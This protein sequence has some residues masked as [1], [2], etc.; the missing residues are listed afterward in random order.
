MATLNI[1]TMDN[2]WTPITTA[3]NNPEAIFKCHKCKR[4]VVMHPNF[5][6][7]GISGCVGSGGCYNTET[8]IKKMLNLRGYKFV[9]LERNGTNSAITIDFL[10]NNV[11]PH[12]SQLTYTCLRKGGS[13]KMCRNLSR[14]KD[15][16]NTSVVKNKCD[17]KTKVCKHY[18]HLLYYPESSLEWDYESNNGVKPEDIAPKS[19]KKKFWWKCSNVWCKMK[20]EQRAAAR[21]G[22]NGY[23]C[24]FCSGQKVC[25]WNC[26]A[27]THPGLTEELD[28]DN[29]IKPTQIT[30]GS[31]E[32]MSWICNKHSPPHKWV[33]SVKKRVA[34]GGC[35]KCNFDGYEQLV[36]GKEHFVSEANKT[37]KNKY[38]YPGEYIDN[39]T[40]INIYCPV[41]NKKSNLPHGNF[42]QNPKD[43]KRGS[44]CIKCT[45]ESISS[46]AL[47][48][49]QSV[50]NDLG[51]PLGENC[52]A[53]HTFTE[54]TYINQLKIDRYLPNENI[55][56]EMDGGYH[57][58]FP[59]NWGGK[60]KLDE[61]HKRDITKDIFCVQNKINLI[62]I[63]HTVNVTQEMLTEIINFCEDGKQLYITYKHYYDEVSKV[64]DLKNV[65][66]S[67]VES[68]LK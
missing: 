30:H 3:K 44:G 25:E 43:H 17:C 48:S 58:K 60:T 32:C 14:T 6:K 26:L 65:H 19:S 67:L 61:I 63:P 64:A 57:F 4:E 50:L 54:M 35:H 8:I 55:A 33:A 12:S 40:L 53:E 1:I 15:K 47:D 21:T 23:R 13:C 11:D 59:E 49:L 2:L 31:N 41:V 68:P 28:P 56:I 7:A 18:N 42:L 34:G 9:N 46:K 16:T 29:V 36:G 24:P 10:C 22:N 62:R 66:I 39:K 38:E 52:I 51:Y 27:T 37:H 20:Y 5:V 45:N